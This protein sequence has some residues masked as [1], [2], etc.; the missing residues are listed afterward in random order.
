MTARL[1]PTGTDRF[2]PARRSTPSDPGPRRPKADLAVVAAHSRRSNLRG[3]AITLIG[4]FVAGFVMVAAHTVVIGQQHQIDSL[5][6]RI[7]AEQHDAQQLGAEIAELQSP[8][9]ITRDAAALLGMV[10]APTPVY[11]E[12]R[13]DDD[14]RAA[15]VPPGSAVTR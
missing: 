5:N 9:R 7:A 13:A 15:E 3:V 6:Q 10:P 14:A 2:A 8:V 4:L 12:P 11:L 1:A